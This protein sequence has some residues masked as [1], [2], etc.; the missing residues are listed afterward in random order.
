MGPRDVEPSRARMGFLRPGDVR[1]QA[2]DF[3]FRP[4]LST[5]SNPPSTQIRR[6][7]ILW[8]RFTFFR[9]LVLFL[10][11]PP[12]LRTTWPGPAGGL[13][14]SMVLG[15]V[16]AR[17]ASCATRP[18]PTPSRRPARIQ[19]LRFV[20]RL[21]LD[22]VPAGKQSGTRLPWQGPGRSQAPGLRQR[23]RPHLRALPARLTRT[24]TSFCHAGLYFRTFIEGP[25][26]PR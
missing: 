22:Q 7:A 24:W 19:D 15:L 6:S 12:G 17:G 3:L 2:R 20:I 25:G 13:P 9:S 16:Q 26:P 4:E 14:K 1:S 5:L 11:A 21:T 23:V 18:R 10:P 8:C